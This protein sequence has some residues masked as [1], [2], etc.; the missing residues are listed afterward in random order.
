MK[1]LYVEN[2]WFRENK[3]LSLFI[4]FWLIP[5]KSTD[6]YYQGTHVFFFEILI[7]NIEYF[8]SVLIITSNSWFNISLRNLML[9]IICTIYLDNFFRKWTPYDLRRHQNWNK[10]SKIQFK[11][12]KIFYLVYQSKLNRIF[13]KKLF[14]IWIQIYNIL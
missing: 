8:I 1:E 2:V 7:G 13:Q 3:F 4:I 11:L 5:F 14:H 12:I 9:S 10:E 6:W